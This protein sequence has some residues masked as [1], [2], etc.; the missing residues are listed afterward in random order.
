L[1]SIRILFLPPPKLTRPPPTPIQQNTKAIAI[2]EE[3][4]SLAADKTHMSYAEFAEVVTDNGGS[5]VDAT[6][7]TLQDAGVII[8]LE[9]VGLSLPGVR[10]VTWTILAVIS[11]C[12][13]P[14]ALLGLSLPGV[15]VWLRGP[16]GVSSFR[17]LTAN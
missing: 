8:K 2:R 7:K 13:R 9:E 16:Y 1:S 10:L 14:Y 6:C 15:S 11:W 5:D 4:E 3:L 12:V 17:V